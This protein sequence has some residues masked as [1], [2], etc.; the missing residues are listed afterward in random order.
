MYFLYF[1]VYHKITFSKVLIPHKFKSISL[2]CI[3]NQLGT[4]MLGFK[5]FHF[6]SATKISTLG[7]K[8]ACFVYSLISTVNNAH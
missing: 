4:C 3:L 8:C 7:H 2:I 5:L 1:Q 6:I